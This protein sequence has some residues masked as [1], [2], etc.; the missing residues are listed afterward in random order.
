VSATAAGLPVDARAAIAARRRAQLEWRHRRLQSWRGRLRVVFWVAVTAVLMILTAA[1]MVPV[2]VLTLFRT[3]RFCA[4]VMTKWLA[5]A[6][7]RAAGVRVVLHRREPFPERQVMYLANHTSTLDCFILLSLGL[8]R[9]RYFLRGKFRRI[10][11][12][13]IIT[14][15]IGTFFTPSQRFPEKRVRCFQRA[16]RVLRRT[17]DSVYL[18]PEG[19]RITDGTTGHFNKGSFHLATDLHIPLLP[20]YIDIP[21][22][23]NPGMG[24]G[25]VPGTVHLYALPEVDTT[26]WRLE[27]LVANKEHVRDLYVAFQSAL[28]HRE[29]GLEYS[30]PAAWRA[31]IAEGLGA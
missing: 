6:I 26:S 7:L 2:A 17:G 25:V 19:K 18:S 9:T 12:L 21:P 30:P 11:P 3:R 4:E 8:P 13:G 16:E 10:V 15:V 1:V 23:I 24:N 20:L 14:H 27:D 29:E 5:R 28:R 31:A 22:Q